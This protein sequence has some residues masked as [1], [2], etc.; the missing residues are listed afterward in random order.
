MNIRYDAILSA[1]S[2]CV[3]LEEQETF[4]RCIIS[5][6]IIIKEIDKAMLF[7]LTWF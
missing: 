6:Y 4:N 3:I 1:N 2:F 7:K 5:W